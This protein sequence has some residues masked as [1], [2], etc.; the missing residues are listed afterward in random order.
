MDRE[1]N[2]FG[3]GNC[4]RNTP[5]GLVRHYRT[6]LVRYRVE[7]STA[8]T[9]RGHRFGVSWATFPAAQMEQCGGA[10]ILGISSGVHE[11][12]I[13]GSRARRGDL[14]GARHERMACTAKCERGE[15]A[16]AT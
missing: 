9:G 11:G 1:W 13:L 4:Y 16:R 8:A 10:E 5:D 14:I 7:R 2:W 3:A 12:A 15:P 6:A